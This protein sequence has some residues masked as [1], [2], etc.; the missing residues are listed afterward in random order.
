MCWERTS[1]LKDIKEI[2]KDRNMGGVE[3][4]RRG[5]RRKLA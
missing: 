1:K 2:C 5:E 4:G 3:R